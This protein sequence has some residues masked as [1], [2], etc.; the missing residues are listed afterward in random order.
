MLKKQVLTRVNNNF[1]ENGRKKKIVK[2]P[3]SSVFGHFF[4]LNLKKMQ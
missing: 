1:S 4:V 2:R 3:S